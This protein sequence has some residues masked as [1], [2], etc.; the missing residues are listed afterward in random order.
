MSRKRPS[1]AEEFERMNTMSD[2][3][4]FDSSDDDR[5]SSDLTD[6]N[7]DDGTSD[8]DAA[9]P[10]DVQKTESD[11]NGGSASAEGDSGGWQEVT[12]DY[13]P[14]DIAFNAATGITAQ[15]GLSPLSVPIDYFRC[16]VTDETVE[17]MVTET[18]RYAQQ[19]LHNKELK[20]KSRVRKWHETNGV[21]MQK[22]IGILLQMG[23]VRKP[24]IEDY[25]STNYILATPDISAVMPHDRFELLISSGIFLTMKLL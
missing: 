13:V 16:F 1:V 19:Y 6:R 3:E 25:W 17:L 5:P 10:D 7:S 9:Q 14:Y 24:S 2:D 22:F 23:L 15:S 4:L 20:A 18:N 21:E 12:A 11:D 8:E